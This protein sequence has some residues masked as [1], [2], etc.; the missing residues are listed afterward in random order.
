[1]DTKI[2]SVVL[3]VLKLLL[4]IVIYPFKT[5]ECRNLDGVWQC[6]RMTNVSYTQFPK[7]LV[8]FT[9]EHENN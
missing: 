8:T 7:I 3:K 1:M 6:E 9:T 4:V 5:R 2:F